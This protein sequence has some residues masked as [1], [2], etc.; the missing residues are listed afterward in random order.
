[1]SSQVPSQY[2]RERPDRR[3]TNVV[4]IIA[5]Y[6]GNVNVSSYPTVITT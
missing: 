6:V 1:L 2:W 4:N 3:G 5:A